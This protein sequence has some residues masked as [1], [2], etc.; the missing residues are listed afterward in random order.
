[1]PVIRRDIDAGLDGDDHA[2]FQ[3]AWHA[4]DAVVA[5]IVHVEAEPVPRLARKVGLVA[6]LG[7][8][9]VRAALQDADGAEAFGDDAHG[10]VVRVA[11][12]ASGTHGV[13][14]GQLGFVHDLVERALLFREASTDREGARDVRRV[15]IHFRACIDQQQIAVFQRGA[16]G[17]VMH[18]AGV[19]AA[20][21]RWRERGHRAAAANGAQD[22]A[23]HL[24]FGDA[25]PRHG[26]RSHVG[27]SCHLAGAP[28]E[29]Q[30]VA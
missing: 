3:H 15:A 23:F 17:L 18:D 22:L 20:R 14:G 11:E 29:R 10:R 16:V 30:L 19:G 21:D 8:R 12:R 9:A 4:V 28:H 25:R 27:R 6:A 26:H 2:F 7:D 24:V 5:D 13:D 1:M